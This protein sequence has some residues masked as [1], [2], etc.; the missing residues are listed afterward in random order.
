MMQLK[1][2]NHSYTYHNKIE[3]VKGGATYFNKLIE[4]IQNAHHSIFVRIYIWSDDTT[5]KLIAEHLRQASKR[6]VSVCITADGY[7]SRGLRQQLIPY[8]R[9]SGIHFKFFEPLL[10]C[11]DFYFGRR[12]HEKVVVIDGLRSLVGGINFSDRYNNINDTACW[13]DY[14]LFVEGEAAQYLYNYCS[15]DWDLKKY[16]SLALAE[17][18]SIEHRSSVRISKND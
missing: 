5:G 6:G 15:I 3:L 12:M 16:T 13:L 4:L 11:K 17:F 7:A 18:N 10:R 14:A 2:Y 8:L 1:E 9:N